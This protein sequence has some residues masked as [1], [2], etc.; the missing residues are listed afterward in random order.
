[1]SL[2]TLG[3]SDDGSGVEVTV[4]L[5]TPTIGISIEEIEKIPVNTKVVKTEIDIKE[6]QVEIDLKTASL[7]VE[8]KE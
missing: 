4:A 7:E 8:V 5:K 1:M 2:I 3:M 6:T